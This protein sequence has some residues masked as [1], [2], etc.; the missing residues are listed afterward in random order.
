MLNFSRKEDIKERL[1]PFKENVDNL[2]L[3]YTHPNTTIQERDDEE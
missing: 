3:E 1:L 2:K